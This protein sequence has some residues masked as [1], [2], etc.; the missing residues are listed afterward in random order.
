MRIAFS[1][2]H[3]VGKS[4]LVQY[5][6]DAL[7]QHATVDEPYYQLEE[8]GYECS[9]P[10]S[11]EDFEAQLARSLVALE[12]DRQNVLFDRCPVDVLAYLLAHEDAAA[13]EI[14]DWTKRTHEAMQT[15]DFVVFV[16]VE[17]R[18]RIALPAHEDRE[19][20]LA[21]HEKLHELLVDDVL[22]FETEVLS[23]HGDLRTRVDQVLAKIGDSENLRAKRKR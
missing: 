1:G 10:P 4:T 2:T 8:E 11:L 3:R 5:V 13:F 16:P 9:E 15:L 12:E 20:R 19:F 7:P 22:G 14:Q 23:V 6:A 21:V 17:E 18:D